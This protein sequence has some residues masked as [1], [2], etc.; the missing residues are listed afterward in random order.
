[1]VT[2][3]TVFSSSLAHTQPISISI[4]KRSNIPESSSYW[5]EMCQ[6]KTVV[7]PS[8]EK[9]VP[10]PSLQSTEEASPTLSVR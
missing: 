8:L 1:M 3:Y 2:T 10:Q 9:T 5:D 6:Q 4:Y 7:Q